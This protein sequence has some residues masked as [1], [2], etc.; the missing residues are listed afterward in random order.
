MAVS[1]FEFLHTVSKGKDA[2]S[3]TV[4]IHDGSLKSPLSFVL[5][6]GAQNSEEK[7]RLLKLFR[8]CY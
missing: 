8:S 7:P 4:L 1:V 2:G 6:N 5:E 3:S